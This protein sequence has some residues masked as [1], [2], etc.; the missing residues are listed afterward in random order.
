M[1]LRVLGCYGAELSNHGTCG[2]L[3]NRSVL[4]DGG[5]IC[6]SLSI[7]E[8]RDIR[9]ILISHIHADH[10]K[11]LPFLS[12]N[13]IGQKG[14]KPIVVISIGEVLAGLRR[15]LF[16]NQVWPDFTRLPNVRNPFFRMR[17]IREG[18]RIKI[19]GLEIQ[20]FRVNHTVPCVG[21][22]IR[23]RNG[24]L[25][26]SGDTYKTDKIWEIAAKAS[27]LKAVM[28][29]TS[30]PD[31]LKGLAV[32]SKHLTPALLLQ[33]FSKIEKPRLPLYIYHM[34]PRYLEAIRRELKKLKIKKMIILKDGM[35]FDI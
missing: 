31:R 4:V 33:E 24:S 32:K 27:D 10:I 16:N 28:I 19:D 25:L 8:Q 21:F 22:L 26:Y 13:L 7:S 17:T 3:I 29:E 20:A 2:F 34:K 30:F 1:R 9:Y 23:Q 14:Q 35:V 5:T 12:E 15:H 11:A 18:E 6:S